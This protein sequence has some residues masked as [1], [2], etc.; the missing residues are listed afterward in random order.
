M[1]LNKKLCTFFCTFQ[2]AL[3]CC[4]SVSFGAAYKDIPSSH[5]AYSAIENLY[6][7]GYLKDFH[8]ENF[9]PDSYI[10]K[11]TTSKILAAVAGYKA[12]DYSAQKNI[13][14]KFSSKFLKWNTESNEQIAFLL[15]KN[16]LTEEDLESFMLFSDDGTEKFRAISREETAVFLVR[17]MGKTAEA[18]K[19][20]GSE[21]FKDNSSITETRRGSVNYLKTINVLSGDKSGF[22][23]PKKA[24][25]RA[26]FC[27]LLNNT[28]NLISIPDKTNSA[29]NINNITTVSGVVNNYYKTLNLIQIKD[30]NEIN[31]YRLSKNVRITLNDKE[32]SAESVTEGAEVSAVINNSEIIRLS[33]NGAKPAENAAPQNT[34]DVPPNTASSD[35]STLC[36]DLSASGTIQSIKIIPSLKDECTL[37]ILSDSGERKLFSGTRYTLP[38][39]SLKIGDFVEITAK[40]GRILT[41]KLDKAKQKNIT[42]GYITAIDDNELTIETAGGEK[43]DFYYSENMTECYDCTTGEKIDFDDVGKF[44]EVYI[45]CEDTNSRIIDVIFVVDNL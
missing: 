28:A 9:N 18:E 31:T 36:M 7:K 44:T 2:I 35:Q 15:S 42:A 24:V 13:I 1:K 19:L 21:L 40:E 41:I 45:F 11:F 30:G 6:S 38:I 3:F 25:T 32:S 12:G 39:Y 37:E 22:C 20:G 16:I 27:V 14:S 33:V 10:D 5:W 17:L 34:A 8:S 23:N 4:S 29:E 43:N 26:E